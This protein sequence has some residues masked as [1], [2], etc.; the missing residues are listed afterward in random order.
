MNF[1]TISSFIMFFYWGWTIVHKSK[2]S[3]LKCLNYRFLYIL[4]DVKFKD[5]YFF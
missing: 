2:F 4:V 1:F 3:E 5:F